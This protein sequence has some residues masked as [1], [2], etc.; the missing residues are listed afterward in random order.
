MPLNSI[1][2]LM[3]DKTFEIILVFESTGSIIYANEAAQKELDY[4]PKI[5]EKTIYDIFPSFVA[6]DGRA[7]NASELLTDDPID[8]IAYRSNKTC[9]HSRTRI[10]MEPSEA[11]YI[12]LSLNTS[13]EVFLKKEISNADAEVQEADKVKTEFVA[14]VTHEL[15]TPVNGILG[16]TRELLKGDITSEQRRYLNLIEK[17]C[18]NMNGIINS[19]LDFSKLEAGKFT[20]E[21]REF[22]F[23]KMLDFVKDN[24]QGRITEKG[25]NFF[26]TIA[27]DVPK[28]IIGD[29]LRITQILNNLLSNATKF[30]SVGK[31]VLE[32]LKTGKAGNKVELFFLVVDTGIGMEKHDLTKLFKSFSQVDAS[33]S[34]NFGGTGLGLNISKQL[35]EMMGGSIACESEKGKGST[36]SFSIWIEVPAGEENAYE[37]VE[38]EIVTVQTQQD[39]SDDQLKIFGSYDNIKEIENRLSKLVLCVEMQNWERAEMFAESI[40]QLTEGA[41]R[42][43]K[44]MTLHLKMAVQKESYEKVIAGQNQLSEYIKTL[45]I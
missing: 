32:V 43:V 29:E 5:I 15:R 21:N 23:R 18:D 30:T 31:I 7:L 16:N 42:E 8:L 9:F 13:E 19:I 26:V 3:L 34:R 37:E 14:N 41:P 12:C 45:S 4:G 38:N 39:D 44:T 27:P 1:S 6:E 11:V 2:S 10:I 33:I 28:T 36:F 40:K 17:S 35:V 22:D 20:L 24:H 25:L